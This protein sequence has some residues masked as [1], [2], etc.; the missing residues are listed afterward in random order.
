MAINDLN[1]G[2]QLRGWTERFGKDPRLTARVVLGLLLVANLVAAAAVL[3]PWGGAEEELQKQRNGLQLVLKNRRQT[4]DRLAKFVQNVERTRTEADQFIERN[5]LDRQTAFSTVLAELHSLAE[6]TGIKPG[7][8]QYTFDPV[9]GSDNL[10]MMTISGSY[11]GT[12]ADLIEFVNAI[13]RSP[14]FITIE[15][16]QALPTQSPGTLAVGLRLNVFVRGGVAGE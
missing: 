13:D 6:K 15:R 8:H 5:F 12:Y 4:A 14:R 9:E 11:A 3:K 2:A 10:E 7:E 16:L 1:V